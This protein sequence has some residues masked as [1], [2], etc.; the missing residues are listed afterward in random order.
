MTSLWGSITGLGLA[1]P[2]GWDHRRVIISVVYLLLRCPAASLGIAQDRRRAAGFAFQIPRPLRHMA[3][4][5]R[6]GYAAMQSHADG[7][8]LISGWSAYPL[9]RTRSRSVPMAEPNAK[10]AGAAHNR[11]YGL[12][13]L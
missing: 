4:S 6:L 5:D 1:G 11:H 12:T 3:L 13:S 2:A 9:L 8:T 7:G 10:A